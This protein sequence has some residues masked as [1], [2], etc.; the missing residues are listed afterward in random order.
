[1]ID[2]LSISRRG[3]VRHGDVALKIATAI[4]ADLY[5]VEEVSAQEPFAVSDIG[6]A[7]EVVGRGGSRSR[8]GKDMSPM[9]MVI[10]KHDGQVRELTY[11]PL[12]EF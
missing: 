9:V 4:F 1:M 7:W 2:V 3:L 8:D 10:A 6:Y 12:S 11:G 5:S